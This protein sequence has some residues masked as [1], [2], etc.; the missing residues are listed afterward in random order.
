MDQEDA[1]Y[2]LTGQ[3][4]IHLW[5]RSSSSRDCAEGAGSGRRGDTH[6]CSLCLGCCVGRMCDTLHQQ[7]KPEV[8]GCLSM[9]RHPCKLDSVL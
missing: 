8:I 3:S 9:V 5:Q 4:I 7:T 2:S 6:L 1:S